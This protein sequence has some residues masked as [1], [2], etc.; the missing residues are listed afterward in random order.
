MAEALTNA[1][2]ASTLHLIRR[3]LIGNGRVPPHRAPPRWIPPHRAPARRQ[4]HHPRRSRPRAATPPP[5]YRSM[6]PSPRSPRQSLPGP[7]LP[8]FGTPY[9]P[10][11]QVD[12][13]WLVGP[14]EGITPFTMAGLVRT[15]T[16]KEERRGSS[17]MEPPTRGTVDLSITD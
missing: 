4:R 2:L 13:E 17:T 15:P 10:R 12:L 8:P 16:T 3:D 6:E 14:P 1:I 7:P 5:Q 9:I 11:T